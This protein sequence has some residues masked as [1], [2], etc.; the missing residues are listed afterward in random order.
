MKVFYTNS[1]LQ[2]CYYVR[3]MVPL[4]E[5]G[6][7]GDRTSWHSEAMAPEMKARAVLDAD[8]VVFHRP[9]DDRSIEIAKK[10]RSQGKK[11]VMDNDDTYKNVDGRV[12]GDLFTKIDK[13]ID[14]FVKYADLVTCSTEFLADEY[15]RLNK[16]VIVL[17]N[18]VDPDDWPEEPEKNETDKVRIGI[19]GSVG[20]NS[21]VTH[22]RHVIKALSE[23]EDVQLVLF[24]L[25]RKDPSTI[26]RVQQLYAREYAYWETL[27]VEW[28]PFVAMQDY[29][30]KL[31][32]L[33][34]D[35][36]LIP[37]SDDYFNRCKSNLKFLEAS[38]LEIPVIA[39]GWADGLSPYQVDP[40]DSAH[41]SIVVD[42]TKWE[43]IIERFIQDKEYRRQVGKK[44]REYVIGKYSIAKN[45]NK[46]KQA[47]QTLL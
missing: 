45:I 20:M 24:S 8:I 9:N 30:E 27:N 13:H 43:G 21:D 1:M 38:M 46:W 19:I 6:W 16:N 39:Q 40:E 34:L 5:G 11:I 26:E 12:L 14:E 47:Y 41:M 10:L 2:G 4:R 25:P 32:S 28:H 42:D 15:R 29:I 18:C 37:R 22:I 36:L 3:A 17:P 44:A 23:R 31:D 7:D 35:M 33:K